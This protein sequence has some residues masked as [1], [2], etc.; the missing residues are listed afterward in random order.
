MSRQNSEK[1]CSA[2]SRNPFSS[3]LFFLHNFPR[4]INPS[5]MLKTAL[6][7]FR[8]ILENWPWNLYDRDSLILRVIRGP[9]M[10]IFI[11]FRCSIGVKAA[12]ND[13]KLTKSF[14]AFY[15][16]TELSH[17]GQEIY[18]VIKGGILLRQ[19]TRSFNSPRIE[20][21]SF[22]IFLWFSD[23]A[24]AFFFHGRNTPTIQCLPSQF[25]LDMGEVP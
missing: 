11:A 15:L 5:V 9:A 7:L 6:W 25:M 1:K 13:S 4:S 20:F 8:L 24:N 19:M 12:V 23:R 14:I 2:R 10:N 16:S 21:L 18:R 22:D 17:E 3:Q